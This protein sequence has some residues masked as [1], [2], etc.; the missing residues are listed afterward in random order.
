MASTSE[1]IENDE[2]GQCATPQRSIVPLASEDQL[3]QQMLQFGKH[4]SLT[5]PNELTILGHIFE[6]HVNR[7][8]LGGQTRLKAN[9]KRL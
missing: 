1:I 2:L 9:Q 3:L 5:N 8:R 6:M 4:S 7:H